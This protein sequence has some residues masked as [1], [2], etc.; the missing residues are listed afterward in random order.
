MPSSVFQIDLSNQ[1]SFES[2]LTDSDEGSA[3]SLSGTDVSAPGG[4]V[5]SEDDSDADSEE[6]A[7][8]HMSDTPMDDGHGGGVHL[9]QLNNGTTSVSESPT[10]GVTLVSHPLPLNQLFQTPAMPENIQSLTWDQYLVTA[11]PPVLYH[12]DAD[13]GGTD[14][15]S[16]SI[17]SAESHPESP[18]HEAM[19]I[20]QIY[21]VFSSHLNTEEAEDE[22][23]PHIPIEAEV[24]MSDQATTIPNLSPPSP[25]HPDADISDDEVLEVSDDE[26]PPP[27]PSLHV[28]IDPSNVAANVPIVVHDVQ[29]H[30]RPAPTLIKLPHYRTRFSKAQCRVQSP[31]SRPCVIVTKNEIFLVQHPFEPGP[32]GEEYGPV[33]VM[34]NPLFPPLEPR[35]NLPPSYHRKSYPLRGQPISHGPPYLVLCP[36]VGVQN[37]SSP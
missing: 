24:G 23:P 14:D 25:P 30:R 2:F 29:W 11:T 37:A 28:A 16:P 36:M 32:S 34:Q 7:S 3:M 13:F 15:E 20:E 6:D 5:H 31:P 21:S 10:F 35:S 8:D 1:D 27:A 4:S 17:V 33:I 12:T 22:I 9:A 18:D 19:A 26:A